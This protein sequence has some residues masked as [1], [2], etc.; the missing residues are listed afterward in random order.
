[1]KPDR[2]TLLKHAA[3]MRRGPTEAE[4]RLWRNLRNSQLDGYKFRRQ[5]VIGSRIADFFCPAKALV[6]EVDG[7]THEPIHDA[8]RDRR[9]YEENGFVTV[10]FSNSDVMSNL[11]GVLDS[12]R[13]ILLD[14]PD[15]WLSNTTPAPSSEEEGS[16]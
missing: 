15:R 11:E 13:L 7:D 16:W 6:V 14:L 9:M 3:D 10:R 2:P 1:M 4:R 5:A 8:F 12:L